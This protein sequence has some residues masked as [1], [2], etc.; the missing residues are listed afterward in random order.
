MSPRS[1]SDRLVRESPVLG[2]DDTV[3]SA[4]RR[5]LDS[6]LP[7]LPVVRRDGALVGIFG[8][9]EFFGALFPGYLSELHFAGF[10]PRSLEAALE[11]RPACR[12]EPVRDH[13][14]T[15]HIDVGTDFSDAQIAE[16]FLHHRVLIV[17]VV[18]DAGSVAGVI[19]RGDF[20]RAVAERFLAGT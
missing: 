18:D 13:M 3:E 19:V 20:F 4:V 8:E 7:A 1:I 10:V 5:L 9:R 2:E 14:N 6:D 16:T 15:D 11:K 12:N 17:P